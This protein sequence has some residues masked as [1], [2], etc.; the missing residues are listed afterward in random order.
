MAPAYER[1]VS[2]RKDLQVVR[3]TLLAM[4]GLSTDLRATLVRMRPGPRISGPPTRSYSAAERSR[5][6]RAART[7]L[8]AAAA[9]IREN[10]ALLERWRAGGVS[11]DADLALYTYASLLDIVARTGDAPRY[12]GVHGP[13]F[14]QI[15]H[16]HGGSERIMTALCL[17]WRE[18]AA[19][20][21]L[22][23]CL[24]GVNGGTLA[25]VPVAHHRADDQVDGIASAIVHLV[26]ARRGRRQRYLSIPLTDLPS[27][28]GRQE[29]GEV[30][31]DEHDQL[32]TPFGIYTL[33]LELTAVARGVTGS[34]R[35]FLWWDPRSSRCGV[36][37]H[38]GW[39][40]PRRDRAHF[41]EGLRRAAVAR[42][43]RTALVP[44]APH[45]C[46]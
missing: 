46:A 5:I 3:S 15:V 27:W 23:I 30:T 42:W 44:T 17:T 24:T 31:V 25:E 36:A 22:L 20:C 26:K 16:R 2:G 13:T 37:G 12:E 41:R 21:V 7:D 34:R 6:M 9:R 1:S 10:T 29:G 14:R 38:H 8:Q 32:S 18:V 39:N 40:V 4:E 35:L 19:A 33:L 28:A 45:P 43:G 11:Q